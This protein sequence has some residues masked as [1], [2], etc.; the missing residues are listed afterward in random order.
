[1][2][3]SELN[4]KYQGS[5]SSSGAASITHTVMNSPMPVPASEIDQELSTSEKITAEIEAAVTLLVNQLD[6]VL[7]QVPP[8][9]NPIATPESLPRNSRIARQ[10]NAHNGQLARIVEVLHTLRQDLCI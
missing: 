4:K 7:V 5:T 1:M 10:L 3:L 8:G 9:G 6:S 2:Y